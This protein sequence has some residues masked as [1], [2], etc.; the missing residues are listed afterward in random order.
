VAAYAEA[1]G[2][3]DIAEGFCGGGLAH[4]VG[5][6]VEG[7]AG[8]GHFVSVGDADHALAVLVELGHLGDF[9]GG[10]FDE[11]REDGGVE[12]E[13]GGEGTW[14]Y[15]VEAGYYFRDR[16]DWG[17]GAAGIDA[18]GWVRE[19]AKGKGELNGG[20]GMG[21]G[22]LR[23]QRLTSGDMPAFRPRTCMSWE[24]SRRVM[25]TATE[26][27]TTTVAPGRAYSPTVYIALWRND[28]SIRLFGRSVVGTEM[29]KCVAPARCP[30]PVAHVTDGYVSSSGAMAFIRFSDT[31]NATTL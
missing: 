14:G 30:G 10:D 8:V 23:R 4:F 18:L 2:I 19:S 20:C 16:L 11:M 22:L 1:G 28:V 27:S 21:C 31:S 26:L 24:S 6:D 25:P 9:G 17:D 7:G 5:V 13:D 29:R 12:V 15:I 3:R